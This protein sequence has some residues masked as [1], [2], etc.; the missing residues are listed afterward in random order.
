MYEAVLIDPVVEWARRAGPV[1]DAE[2]VHL[3][4]ATDETSATFQRRESFWC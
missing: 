3:L 4:H 1:A 2:H